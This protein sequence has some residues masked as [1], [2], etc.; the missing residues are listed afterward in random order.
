MGQKLMALTVIAL[1]A[2]LPNGV[3]RVNAAAST[4]QSGAVGPQAES[5]STE[6]EP[7]FRR[8][9][10]GYYV[11]YDPTSWA[12]LEANAGSIDVV[13]VQWVTIDG[14]GRLTSDDDQTLKQFA[15]ARG[16]KVVPSLLTLSGWLNHRV[17]T[18]PETSDRA[19]TEI[20]EYVVAEE[21][22]GFDLDLEAVRPD[23]RAAYARFV[24]RLAN[25]LRERGKML[26]LAIP[27]KA[28]D[29]TTGWAGAFDYAALGQHADLITIM[30]Y[31]Y[32]GA[33]GGPGPI[34]P[35][36][37]VGRVAAF[38]ASQIPPRKVLLGVAFYGFDWNVTSGGARYLGHPE[39]AA[40]AERHGVPIAM[41]PDSRSATFR[42]RA[43]AGERPPDVARPP[44]L[45][46]EITVRRPPG[47]PVTDPSPAPRPTPRPVP[48][49]DAIQEHE[50]W[51]EEHESAV[52]RLDLADRYGVGGV[53]LWRLGH[54][55]ARVWPALDGW[56]R[57]AP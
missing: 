13:A 49:A 10:L 22:D 56:R 35:Y 18:D 27:A 16:I 46:H 34:A 43:P 3:P 33:W 39:A 6:S 28:T 15:Q 57:S 17:L 40:L 48:P 55:E 26:A 32:H 44:A 54:E 51:L 53:A 5:T 1:L 37:D 11:P 20:V 14:C 21:Y 30:A 19:L 29:T 8:Q 45:D 24:E 31:E 42:Y 23:D 7:A 2:L 38:A 47:C 50:V 36:G 9:V 25:A 52:A 41:A 4:P 12:S